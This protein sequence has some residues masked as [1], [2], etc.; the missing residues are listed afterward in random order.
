MAFAFASLNSGSTGTVRFKG[1]WGLDGLGNFRLMGCTLKA[2]GSGKCCREMRASSFG[3]RSVRAL[4]LLCHRYMDILDRTAI[5]Q[6]ALYR[7]ARRLL[8]AEFCG[9]PAV[10]CFA[11]RTSTGS[12]YS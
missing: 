2:G 4:L 10:H 5:V 11:M 12:G 6:V 7:D 3:C 8:K 9:Q 1:D